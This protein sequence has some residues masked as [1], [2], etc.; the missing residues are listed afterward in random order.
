MKK[1][2]VL[3]A[4][5]MAGVIVFAQEKGRGYRGDDMTAR[6]DDRRAHNHSVAAD[7]D[8]KIKRELSLTD[9]QYDRFQEA[10]KSYLEKL[11]HM[12]HPSRNEGARKAEFMK[13]RNDYERSMKS[14]LNKKQY[15]RWSDMRPS[16][17]PRA[18]H[19]RGERHHS[20]N[21]MSRG[22]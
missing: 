20:H 3:I 6:R 18:H 15:Q 13:L 21:D 7:R 12:K 2:L 5:M 8:A 4:F 9:R 19:H 11:S 22:R 1:H 17:H 10:N 14:I 16:H